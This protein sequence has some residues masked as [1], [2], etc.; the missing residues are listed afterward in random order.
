MSTSHS[1]IGT[2][3]EEAS[4]E[5]PDRPGRRLR[6]R[7]LGIVA[8]AFFLIKGLLWLAIPGALLLW[9]WLAD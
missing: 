5:V 7:H 8:F 9:R 6:L 1:Q 2:P 3:P 4:A